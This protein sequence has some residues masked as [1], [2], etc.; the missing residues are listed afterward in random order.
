[1]GL[2][3]V[4]QAI[5]A[6]GPVAFGAWW[7][8]LPVDQR[9]E[10]SRRWTWVARPEQLAP[11]GEWDTWLCLAGRGF[12]KT[13]VGAEWAKAEVEVETGGAGRFAFIA[14]T[15]A[16]ARDTMVEGE[17]GLLS[18]YAHV[19]SKRDRP[20]YEP[21]KRR[22]TWPNGALATLF[23]AEEPDRL[24]GPQHDRVWGDELAAWDDP[25]GCYDMA[26]L[27]LRLG[28]PRS[29]F[30][31]TPR[32]IPLVRQLLGDPTT[33]VTRGSTYENAA[34]LAPVFLRKVRALYE[35]TRLGRQ[36]L[37]AEVLDDNPGAL[38]RWAMIEAARVKNAPYEY[39][40]VVTAIDPA[41]SSREDS[42]ETGIVTCGRA[43]CACK[44]PDK[45]EDHAFV[46]A[47]DSA[48]MTPDEWAKKAAKAYDEHDADRVVGEV[49]NG[50]DL[51]E[52]NLRTLG[53]SDISYRSV[54]A[55]R[56]KK[57]RA[58]PISALYEQGKVHHIG[59]FPKLEDQMTQWNPLVDV[60][61]PDRLDA[62]VWALTDLM[63][64]PIPIR[65]SGPR[66]IRPR[67]I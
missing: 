11:R 41:V 19:P 1:M 61:S 4:Q 66:K 22:V 3:K 7:G 30:T 49:N 56:G 29:L 6:V 51:V 39:L 8:G 33:V 17:S 62:L 45:I 50:G 67:R 18:L 44:G 28:Q 32:P 16:D 9:V 13:R 35:G 48:I 60:W 31:T 21:S 20:V 59:T 27:G 10:L 26:M 2:S 55:S 42:A 38:W 54:H 53:N 15:A 46:I 24:R 63:M 43:R 37:N 57:I 52:S 58:E 12:G 23:S 25:Q 14:P 5:A 34:N 36:E 64:G 65:S 40:R 47:D